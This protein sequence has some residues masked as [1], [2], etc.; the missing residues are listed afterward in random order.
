VAGSQAFPGT[1][2]LSALVGEPRGP[3]AFDEQLLIIAKLA[4]PYQEEGEL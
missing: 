4:E 3:P 1:T 2:G